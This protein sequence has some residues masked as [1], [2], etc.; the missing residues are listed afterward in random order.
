[1]ISTSCLLA[2][3]ATGAAESARERIGRLLLELEPHASELGCLDELAHAWRL[4]AANGACR[5]RAV[6]ARRGVRGLLE[7]LADETERPNI[8]EQTSIGELDGAS[9]GGVENRESSA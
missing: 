7:W 5:Q 2:D 1:V 6:V 9:V 3:P 4:L 8:Q